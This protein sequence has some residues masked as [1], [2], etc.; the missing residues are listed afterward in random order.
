MTFTTIYY[1]QYIWWLCWDLLEVWAL[2]KDR[3]VYY[4]F[5]ITPTWTINLHNYWICSMMQNWLVFAVFCSTILK[6]TVVDLHHK[7]IFLKRC[8]NQQSIP[9]RFV[10]YL[11]L[12]R[13]CLHTVPIWSVAS[14]INSKTK[15]HYLT[16]HWL[17]LMPIL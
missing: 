6:I 2:S 1:W 15:M 12:C 4:W 10:F 11:L 5:S 13:S 16:L 8:S 3:Y 14:L 9:V 17:I 7:F